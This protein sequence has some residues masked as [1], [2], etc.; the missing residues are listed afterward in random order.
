MLKQAEE[1]HRRALKIRQYT[2]GEDHPSTVASLCHLAVSLQHQ[3]RTHAG[4][5]LLRRAVDIRSKARGSFR[6]QQHHQDLDFDDF[7]MEKENDEESN[8]RGNQL[9]SPSPSSQQ[10]LSGER[11]MATTSFFASS[12]RGRSARYNL[13][14]VRGERDVSVSGSGGGRRGRQSSRRWNG[15]V[16][17]RRGASMSAMP[18]NIFPLQ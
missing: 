2:L 12:S 1:L 5:L 14:E 8:G 6:Q 17:G 13:S 16:R 10:K 9:Q 15:G 11:E 18:A 7:D 4:E 3:G